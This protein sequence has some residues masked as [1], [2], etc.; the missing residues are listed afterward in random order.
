MPSN[1]CQKR[2]AINRATPVPNPLD[3]ADA[4]QRIER[5]YN[6]SPGM[7]AIVAAIVNT[8]IEGRL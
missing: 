4:A 3:L 8:S 2:P 7:A 6:A 1:L 5:R